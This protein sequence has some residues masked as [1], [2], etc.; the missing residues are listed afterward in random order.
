MCKYVSQTEIVNRMYTVGWRVEVSDSLI[1]RL[2]SSR[3]LTVL[4]L[5]L[6]EVASYPLCNKLY[7]KKAGN[8]Y[9]SVS[10]PQCILRV[11]FKVLVLCFIIKK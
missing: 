6:G 5:T 10:L 8:A 3:C 7:I 1:D 11:A 9:L 4:S 2:K